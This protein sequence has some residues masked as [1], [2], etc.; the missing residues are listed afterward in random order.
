MVGDLAVCLL[1]DSS[2]TN[3][4]NNALGSPN[5]SAAPS[6]AVKISFSSVKDLGV[7]RGSAVTSVTTGSGFTLSENVTLP[8]SPVDKVSLLVPTTLGVAP[9]IPYL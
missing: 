9:P 6:I 2:K 5:S 3:E 8:N 4:R 1:P 7:V